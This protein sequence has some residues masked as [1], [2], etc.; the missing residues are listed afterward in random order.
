MKTT[1]SILCVL[2]CAQ[3]AAA[4]RLLKQQHSVPILRGTP[5]QLETPEWNRYVSTGGEGSNVVS[6]ELLQNL[7]QARVGQGSAFDHTLLVQETNKAGQIDSDTRHFNGQIIAQA[8]INRAASTAG[9]HN[10]AKEHAG[11]VQYQVFGQGLNVDNE[12]RSALANLDAQRAI[13]AN[14]DL[15]NA[16]AATL[17]GSDS[18]FA[19]SFGSNTH[20]W[21]NRK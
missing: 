6:S 2:C 9:I 14:I 1:I 13:Q 3:W 19:T 15:G 12:Q 5:G 10:A 4:S 7:V 20:R 8:A 18:A 16:Y 21:T 17:A 11:T